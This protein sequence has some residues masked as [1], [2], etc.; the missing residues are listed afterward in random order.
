MNAPRQLHDT[1]QRLWLDNITKGL[2]TSGTLARYIND[3]YVTGVTSNPTILEKAISGSDDYDQ[4]IASALNAG[5]TSPEDL[6]FAIALQDLVAAADLLRPVFDASGATD[7]YVS[8]E[9]SPDLADDADATI[10]AGKKLFAQAN[11]PNVMIKVPGTPAG[12]GAIEELIAAGIPVNVTLLFSPAHY[13]AASDAYLRGV[14]RRLDDGLP[15][16]VGSVASVFVSR[17]DAA[18]DPHLPSELEGK[19]ALA[20]MQQIF[21]AYRDV[22]TGERWTALAAAGALPQKVLW[23]STGTKNPA[24]PDTYYLGR[25]A[26][27]GTVDTIP[28]ATML[29]F[30]DHGAVCDL[31]EPDPAGADALLSAVSA[32]GVNIAELA[33][34]LQTDGAA[35]FRSSWADLLACVVRKTDQLGPVR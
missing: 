33:A 8:V 1:G 31:L 17:W 28:E 15:L 21:A 19:T 3:L 16:P 4:P 32:A 24:L 5:A 9:V 18:A 26:A 25:L 10:E 11:R 34:T 22:L 29:A 7:G 6:A 27:P 2:I 13:Q 12:K 30:A 14:E 35:A 23:A 20:V